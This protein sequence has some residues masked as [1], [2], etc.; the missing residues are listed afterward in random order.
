[1]TAPTLDRPQTP[2]SDLDSD[3]FAS[4]LLWVLPVL[5]FVAAL[6]GLG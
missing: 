3:L 6:L 4:V 5:G 2:P 1:M